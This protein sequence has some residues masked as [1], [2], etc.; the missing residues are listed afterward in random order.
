MD[1][2]EEKMRIR[3]EVWERLVRSGAALPPFPVR[4]RIPNFRGADAAARRL[5]ESEVFRKARVVFCNPDS[6]QRYVREAVLRH[7]KT[8]IMASPRLREGFLILDPGR[9]PE[10]EYRYASTIRG[11][12]AYGEKVLDSL[13]RVDLKV[14]GSVAVD[15]VGGR[16]GKGGG[17][18]DLEYA[19]LR[20]LNALSDETP[21]VTTVHD[22]QVVEKVPMDVHDVPVDYVFTPT[23]HFK[24]ARAYPRPPGILWER[25]REED[26]REIPVLRI[27]AKR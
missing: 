21:I 17:F 22:L 14:A 27:L 18:S 11:A 2:R 26:L 15:R 1:P 10:E 5:V 24:T 25:L 7:G 9:V 4:G 23:T 13:P 8:L 12:F 3:E 20:T 19:I 6:P 16:V